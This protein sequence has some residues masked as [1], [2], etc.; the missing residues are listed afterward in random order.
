MFPQM[1]IM[2]AFKVKLSKRYWKEQKISKLQESRTNDKLW[3]KVYIAFHPRLIRI[4]IRTSLHKFL[5]L[6]PN[7]FFKEMPP[8]V[9]T[10]VLYILHEWTHHQY[11]RVHPVSFMIG[12]S[13]VSTS[14]PCILNNWTHHQSQPLHQVS[15]IIGSINCLIGEL[16]M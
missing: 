16:P 15:V 14:A 11:Q 3:G 4:I 5:N 13:L 6:D 2:Y 8:P 1:L 12:P 9:S 10:S 7:L